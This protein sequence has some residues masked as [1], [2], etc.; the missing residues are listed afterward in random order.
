MEDSRTITRIDTGVR[1][2]ID[3]NQGFLPLMEDTRNNNLANIEVGD[4]E[5]VYV[6]A[7]AG[8]YVG[9]D[10]FHVMVL[11][12]LKNGQDIHEVIDLS[13][14]HLSKAMEV[15][16]GLASSAFEVMDVQEVNI[17]IHTAKDEWVKTPKQ[18][19]KSFK[20]L[21]IH[22]EAAVY[23]NKEDVTQ[24]ELRNNPEYYGKTPEPFEKIGYQILQNEILP[25]LRENGI[26]V[27]DLFEEGE[28]KYGRLRL[29]LL[30]GSETFKLLDLAKFMQALD[31]EGQ[32][33]YSDLARCFF[34]VEEDGQF[35]V[36]NGKYQ[37]YQ[38]LPVNERR[39]KIDEYIQKREWLTNGSKGG[40]R[41]LTSMAQDAEKVIDREMEKIENWNAEEHGGFGKPTV[42]QIANRFMA[43]RGFSYA[44]LFSATKDMNN[45]IKWTLGV[46]PN[47]FLTE[48]FIEMANTYGLIVK[49]ADRP[50]S[51]KEL[52]SV[53]NR[54]KEIIAK[55]QANIRNLKDGPGIENGI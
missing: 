53:Q 11:P 29:T 12:D 55:V 4:G 10:G 50:Y 7:I 51:E 46:R 23:S 43:F 38:L 25:K 16:G 40:L 28:D 17:G 32:K 27:D 49:H 33:S 14:E 20:N 24:K 35:K 8:S 1:H 15:A 26:R 31:N 37:R 21:H 39:K 42:S 48:G 13:T 22:I 36:D 9:T 52:K 19:T 44:T 2:K 41:L 34:E 3:P 45:N 6:K 30:N 18:K 54:E 47:V 5:V